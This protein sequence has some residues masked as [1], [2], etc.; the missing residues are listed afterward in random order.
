VDLD[1][2][3]T[4]VE[5]IWEQF[6]HNLKGFIRRRVRNEGDAEDILQEVFLKIHSNIDGLREADKVGAWLHQIT[7]NAIVDYYRRPGSTLA[8]PLEA[9]DGMVD[10]TAEVGDFDEGLACLKPMIAGL[11]EKYR[12][13]LELTEY[14]GMTQ[15]EAAAELGISV[16]GAKS[17]VQRARAR[18]REML[19]DCCHFEFDHLGNILDY[20]LRG[21]QCAFC[22]DEEQNN[23]VLFRRTSV[24]S[25][26]RPNRAGD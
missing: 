18:L 2:T 8:S 14:G 17:R 13:A 19:L 11:P 6:D 12:R 1:G 3:P 26:G 22:S 10:G 25:Y 16:S 5:E 7:R 9:A 23:C 21:R 24:N 4:T 20:N 15:R